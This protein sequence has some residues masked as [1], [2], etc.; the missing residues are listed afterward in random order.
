MSKHAPYTL[1]YKSIEDINKDTP[2]YL[3]ESARAMLKDFS[4]GQMD[5]NETRN[6]IVDI[7][8]ALL[9]LDHYRR[10]RVQQGVYTLP[11]PEIDAVFHQ[12]EQCGK[13]TLQVVL[14][15]DKPNGAEVI[16]TY[17]LD[18]PTLP[19]NF[20]PILLS[21]IGRHSVK[22]PRGYAEDKTDTHMTVVYAVDEEF[23]EA[24]KS[25]AVDPDSVM[26][27]YNKFYELYKA[28]ANI[29]DPIFVNLT[30]GNS[31]YV[32][33]LP[34]RDNNVAFMRI[35]KIVEHLRKTFK[36][37]PVGVRDCPFTFG[38]WGSED[39]HEL[40]DLQAFASSL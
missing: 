38:F 26:K 6:A 36:D 22:Y 29:H 5:S 31:R 17:D 8:R 3:L 39:N 7:E 28:K 23:A 15:L 10:R 21:F 16:H 24:V 33:G 1:G 4:I 40:D 30:T 11:V 32:R 13:V 20:I 9:Q 34:T 12:I 25:G 37:E 14:M 2:E 18:E 19:S 27:L 35:N